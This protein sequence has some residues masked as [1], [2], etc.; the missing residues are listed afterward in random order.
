[1]KEQEPMEHKIEIS[2]FTMKC[3]RCGKVIMGTTRRQLEHTFGLH[4]LYCKKQR[5]QQNEQTTTK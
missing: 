3:N 2:R 4:L 5:Q 1:M